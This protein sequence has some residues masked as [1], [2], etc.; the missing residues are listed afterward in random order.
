MPAIEVQK[1]TFNRMHRDPRL[2]DSPIAVI[3]KTL[4]AHP[5]EHALVLAPA[6]RGAKAA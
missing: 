3:G 2:L 5:S 1:S 6:D 4:G